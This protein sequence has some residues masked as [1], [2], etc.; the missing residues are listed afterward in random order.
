MDHYQFDHM[1]EVVASSLEILDG[2]NMYQNQ[3]IQTPAD[4][5]QL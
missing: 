4:T 5:S 1:I 2:C 3:L